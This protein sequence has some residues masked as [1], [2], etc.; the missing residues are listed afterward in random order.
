MRTRRRTLRVVPLLHQLETRCLLSGYTQ[1]QTAG[2]TP[3]P[4]SSCLWS[5][6]DNIDSLPLDRPSRETARARRS[7]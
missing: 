7:P 6:C 1:H 2:Y 3:D 5:Q 4:D